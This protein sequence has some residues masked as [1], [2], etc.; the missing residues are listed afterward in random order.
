MTFE[1]EYTDQKTVKKRHLLDKSFVFL[2]FHVGI[3]L[4][5]AFFPRLYCQCR[6]NVLFSWKMFEEKKYWKEAISCRRQVNTR[7]F[8]YDLNAFYTIF[9]PSTKMIRLSKYLMFQKDFFARCTFRLPW[10]I[11]GHGILHESS[12][13]PC[14]LIPGCITFII[15]PQKTCPCI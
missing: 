8:F 7:G 13:L 1:I 10:Q 12:A 14:L 6:W 11:N 4:F 3:F 2:S 15:T 9:F 5:F